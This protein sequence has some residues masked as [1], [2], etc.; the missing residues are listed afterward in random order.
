MQNYNGDLYRYSIDEFYA[1]YLIAT[2]LKFITNERKTN[3]LQIKKK[4][5]KSTLPFTYYVY[6]K[7]DF[8]CYYRQNI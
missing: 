7:E 3:S 1:S 6:H 2:R 5:R 8:E 4:N